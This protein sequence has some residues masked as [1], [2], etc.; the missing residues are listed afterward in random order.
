MPKSKCSSFRIDLKSVLF[1]SIE[2]K[3]K[4]SLCTG[5]ELQ[6]QLIDFKHQFHMEKDKV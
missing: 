4:E 1:L 3:L 6:E 2:E 5:E